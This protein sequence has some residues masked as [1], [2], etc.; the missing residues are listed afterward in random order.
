LAQAIL[1]QVWLKLVRSGLLTTCSICSLK[2]V[3]ASMVF[4]YDLV[5]PCLVTYCM[6][7]L[8]EHLFHR[9]V[10]HNPNMKFGRNHITHHAHVQKD[11]S[12]N[13]KGTDYAGLEHEGLYLY[14]WRSFGGMIAGAIVG[15]SILIFGFGTAP[16][17]TFILWLI[18][19]AWQ[20]CCWNSMHAM[21]HGRCGYTEG[22]PLALPYGFAKWLTNFWYF[23]WV[24]RNHTLHHENKGEG[25]GNF[26]IVWPGADFF[27]GTYHSCAKVEIDFPPLGRSPEGQKRGI[28]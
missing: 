22:Q 13:T 20:L 19:P 21:M 7:S 2:A 23:S 18:F 25:K 27:L 24:V 6:Y 8:S 12:L 28:W 3:V 16:M 10:M 14:G 26:N 9:F 5:L 1:A 11:M 15:S 4:M 17:P